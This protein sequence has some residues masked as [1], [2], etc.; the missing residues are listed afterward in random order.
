MTSH[1]SLARRQS[2]SRNRGARSSERIAGPECVLFPARD[3][4]VAEDVI[5]RSVPHHQDDDLVVAREPG[6][7]GIAL[8]DGG[9][10]VLEFLLGR[11]AAAARPP[12]PTS[13]KSGA[14][15]SVAIASTA[16]GGETPTVL[17]IQP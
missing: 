14:I 7:P 9:R 15:S 6:R 5:E 2:E 16:S 13:K 11:P 17:V 12:S 1:G 3:S 8:A 4:A 10:T